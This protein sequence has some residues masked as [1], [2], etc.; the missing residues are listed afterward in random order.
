M[1]GQSAGPHGFFIGRFLFG[2]WCSAVERITE[3]CSVAPPVITNKDPIEPH[4]EKTWFCQTVWGFA[5]S[6]CYMSTGYCMFPGPFQ[7]L[8]A[9]E[10]GTTAEG[11]NGNAVHS[12]YVHTSRQDGAAAEWH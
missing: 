12:M 8:E 4:G 7:R 1:Q 5:C 10:S 11:C 2:V 3:R 9:M 6:E